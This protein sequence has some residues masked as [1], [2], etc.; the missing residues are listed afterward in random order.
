[1]LVTEV[2]NN[3][4]SANWE[5]VRT[6]NAIMTAEVTVGDYSYDVNFYS[7]DQRVNAWIVEF[8]DIGQIDP[9]ASTNRGDAIAVLSA[10]I[11]VIRDAIERQPMDVLMF[12][13]KD[14][15][16]Q[17]VYAHI[18]KKLNLPFEHIKTPSGDVR[19]VIPLTPAGQ[20]TT[21][22]L[23]RAVRN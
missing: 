8:A 12:S 21:A 9:F 4:P 1:M 19:Y 5:W 15:G 23:T 6:S 17:R 13:A 22:N 2:F 14:A 3:K 7:F 16:R 18:L 11:A 10:V 20:Q